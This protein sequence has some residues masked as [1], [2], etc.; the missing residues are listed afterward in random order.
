MADA[1][2]PHLERGLPHVSVP[3]IAWRVRWCVF[4]TIGA[5]RVHPTAA[6]ERPC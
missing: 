4:G 3:V 5:L 1:F 2:R 6:F